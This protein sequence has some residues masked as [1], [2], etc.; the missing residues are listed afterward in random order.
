LSGGCEEKTQAGKV[1][2]C[3]TYIVLSFDNFSPSDKK[4]AFCRLHPDVWEI[5]FKLK[6][7]I[8]S[9]ATVLSCVVGGAAGATT[10]DWS[11]AGTFYDASGTIQATFVSG[12]EYQVTSLTGTD[13]FGNMLTGPN[14]ALTAD[15]LLYYGP[16][17]T[18]PDQIDIFG[19]G[20]VVTGPD[21]GD[22]KFYNYLGVTDLLGACGGVCD[23]FIDAGN[24]S[25][26][27]TPLPAA[28]P[29]F[30]GGLGMVGFLARRGKRKAQGELAAA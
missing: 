11:Y 8:A 6:I 18:P 7:V 1:K 22:A 4:L 29:L 20:F 26:S 13:D 25:V 12:V 28:L 3:C 23:P 19:I 9:I 10:F 24:F 16:G 2:Y 27:E 5:M 15:N 17:V 14:A 30:A 21:A